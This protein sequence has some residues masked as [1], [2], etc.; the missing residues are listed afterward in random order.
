VLEL[1]VAGREVV[2]WAAQGLRSALD[3]E[4]IAE[5]REV[6]ATGAFLPR[7]DDRALTF[8]AAGPETFVDDQTGSTWD[9]LGRAVSGPLVGKQLEATG[10]LDTFWFAWAA[11]HPQTR[12]VSPPG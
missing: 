7:A 8:G 2:V 3:T 12:L 10:H 6:A 4:D 5:G 9:V 1:E 11:F